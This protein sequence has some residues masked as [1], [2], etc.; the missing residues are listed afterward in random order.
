MGVFLAFGAKKLGSA[1]CFSISIWSLY[2]ACQR[3]SHHEGAKAFGRNKL[4]KLVS[5][6]L[7]VKRHNKVFSGR[8][9]YTESPFNAAL[10][11][12]EKSDHGKG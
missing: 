11:K 6:I 10:Y 2:G 9:L 1:S 5:A 7:Q 12:M 3:I 4:G 8:L